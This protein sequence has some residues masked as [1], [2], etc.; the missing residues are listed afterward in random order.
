MR[1]WRA[2]S[3][4]T[5]TGC[6]SC[7]GDTPGAGLRLPLPKGEGRDR[8]G[9]RLRA[10]AGLL[11]L[12]GRRHGGRLRRRQRLRLARLHQDGKRHPRR[13]IPATRRPLPLRQL[14]RRQDELPAWRCEDGASSKTTS[15][16]AACW[17][18]GRRGL[19]PEGDRRPA[20]AAWR[21]SSTPTNAPGAAAD[22]MQEP[23]RSRG[24]RP[25]K[26]VDQ[27][28]HDGRGAHPLHRPRR[29]ARPT[30]AIARRTR[31]R[32]AW[33]STARRA[34]TVRKD[35]DRRPRSPI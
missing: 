10:P 18:A 24:G 30:F 21:A 34:S 31:S 12:R 14:R 19:Q 23:R 15:A 1:R 26:A 4:P 16:A 13:A 35:D 11:G 29:R 28:P 20:G 17:R 33:E 9:G 7:D 22:Q 25:Q 8:D 6:I 27:H 3:P 2:S 32:S 5:A